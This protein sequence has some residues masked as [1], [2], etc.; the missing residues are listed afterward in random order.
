MCSFTGCRL[1]DSTR[2]GEADGGKGEERILKRSGINGA[3]EKIEKKR[4]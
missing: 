4:S 2:K 1:S 3:T